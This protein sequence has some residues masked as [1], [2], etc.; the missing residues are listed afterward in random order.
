MTAPQID[1]AGARVP[2]VAAAHRPA[3]EVP[4]VACDPVWKR[5]DDRMT[6]SLRTALALLVL[7]I[8]FPAAA[9]NF[10]PSAS[11][12]APE[13]AFEDAAGNPL[14]LEDFRGKVVVLNLWATWCGPCRK[15]MPSLDRLQA[16]FG[17]D[18]V[19]VLPLSLDRG[20]LS[21]IQAF[22]DEVGIQNLQIYRDPKGAASH[23]LGAFGL[24][25]TV[26]LD[27]DG[28]EVGRVLGPAEWDGDEALATLRA[29]LLGP[30]RAERSG[31]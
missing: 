8:P 11:K 20:E 16:K 3:C 6:R 29:V 25:T 5:L 26:V 10:A 9:F 12:P 17:G 19:V 18:G 23:V 22:Y 1:S 30:Q 21:R 27:R 4:R 7:I 31:D 14:T 15:E 28:R 2:A 13:L 24:P